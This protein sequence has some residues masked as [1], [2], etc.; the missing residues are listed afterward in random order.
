MAT[1]SSST[2]ETSSSEPTPPSGQGGKT[3]KSRP[4]HQDMWPPNP[5]QSEHGKAKADEDAEQEKEL[6]G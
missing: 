6:H 4:D 5:P 1:K 2:E 3:P